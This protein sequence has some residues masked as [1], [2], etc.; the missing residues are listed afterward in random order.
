M[1]LGR[2]PA[3]IEGGFHVVV[4]SP[5]GSPLK[6][7]L[8]PELQVMVANRP[9]PLGFV[10]PYDWGFVPST[11]APDGD[12][13]DALVCWDVPTFPGV[14]IACRAL[15]VLRL[16]QEAKGGGR[17]RNDRLVAIPSTTR[18]APS[19]ARPGTSHPACEEIAHFFTSSVYF[20]P[21]TGSWVGWSGGPRRS[22]AARGGD[23][24]ALAEHLAE[25]VRL[26]LEVPQL[27]VGRSAEPEVQR[28]R[29]VR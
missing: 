3:L 2:V 13:L 28:D 27:E 14:V 21:K 23:L 10:Y 20:E 8:D 9:L 22:S 7:K 15:G 17:E 29:P 26:A 12:P 11:R 1:Q 6:L 25:E 16:E 4:E 24:E 5:R 19:C 18:A